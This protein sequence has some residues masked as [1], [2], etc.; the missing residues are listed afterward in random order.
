F[1]NENNEFKESSDDKYS[2]NDSSSEKENIDSTLSYLQNLKKRCN[3]GR[4]LY[5]KYFKASYEENQ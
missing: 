2:Q 4:P 5:T 1:A 3:R